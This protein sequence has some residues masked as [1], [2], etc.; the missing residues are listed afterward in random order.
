MFL[1]KKKKNNVIVNFCITRYNIKRAKL[2]YTSKCSI[3]SSLIK[4]KDIITSNLL[5]SEK[6]N[7]V[8]IL[9]VN[10]TIYLN[11]IRESNIQ[12]PSNFI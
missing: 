11:L 3:L 1:S 6:D 4:F 9:L 2:K 5:I 7:I 8:Y 12:Y 10:E